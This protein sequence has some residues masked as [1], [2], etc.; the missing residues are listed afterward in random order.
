MHWLYE[1]SL[2]N[3]RRQQRLNRL[4]LA[5]V[6]ELAIEHARMRLRVDALEA[7]LSPDDAGQ[8]PPS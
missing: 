7:R 4:L 1:Y 8:L 2:E 3:F 5:V 6:E